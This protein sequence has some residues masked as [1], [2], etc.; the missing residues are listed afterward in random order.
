MTEDSA[1]AQNYGTEDK[2]TAR[3]KIQAFVEEFLKHLV[4]LDGE[5]SDLSTFCRIDMSIYV[6]E[7]KTVQFF[8]NE[9][10]RGI[11]TCLWTQDGSGPIG[12]IGTDLAWP[13]ARWIVERKKNLQIY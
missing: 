11:T 7:D 2:N 13:L 3:A 6:D 8:V 1:F 5:N 4:A 10:E 12:R 9:V